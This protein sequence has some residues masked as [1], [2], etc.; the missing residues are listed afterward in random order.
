[1]DI[2]ES[3]HTGAAEERATFVPAAGKDEACNKCISSS[4]DEGHISRWR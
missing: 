1:V 4:L 3:G 2:F